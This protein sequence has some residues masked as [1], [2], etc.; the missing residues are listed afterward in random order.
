MNVL[1]LRFHSGENITQNRLGKD[2]TPTL[3]IALQNNQV[4]R[5]PASSG[6][7]DMVYLGHRLSVQK[8]GHL[9]AVPVKLD[10]RGT[11]G[12]IV[13]LSPYTMRTWTDEDQSRLIELAESTTAYLKQFDNLQSARDELQQVQSALVTLKNEKDSAIANQ[14]TLLAR[15][16]ELQAATKRD[17]TPT[18]EMLTLKEELRLALEEIAYLN[19]SQERSPDVQ[20]SPGITRDDMAEILAVA[21]EIRQPMSSLVGYPMYCC[22]VDGNLGDASEKLVERFGCQ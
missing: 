20:N 4:L 12:G 16:R 11:V 17:D 7:A 13:I 14:E 1:G 6:S 5:L 10:D 22:R 2:L 19:S 15:I 3:G 9:M 18:E 8:V 21:E